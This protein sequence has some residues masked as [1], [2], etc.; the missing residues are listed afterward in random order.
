[1]EPSVFNFPPL[2]SS[3][4]SSII[5]SLFHSSL[6]TQLFDKLFHPW[7]LYI[8][9]DWIHELGLDLIF[10]AKRFCIQFFVIITGPPTHSVG[11]QYCFSL[12]RLSSSSVTLHG[13]QR[14]SPGATRD[15]GPVV[16]RP[17]M[18]TPCFS[19]CGPCCKSIIHAEY[20]RW[21]MYWSK[22]L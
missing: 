18:A 11:G 12:W 8:P 7:T 20:S 6:K 2:S 16:S 1:V 15:G 19:V 5:P 4:S 3:L 13:A 22:V 10:W 21:C 17:V 14:N 9:Q